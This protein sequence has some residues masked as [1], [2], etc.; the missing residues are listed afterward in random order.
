M[1]LICSLAFLR[2]F[3]RTCGSAGTAIDAKIGIDNE[4]AVAF[5]NSVYRAFCLASAA[6]DAFICDMISHFN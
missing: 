6:G 4:F 5:G 1:V 2:S 3:N